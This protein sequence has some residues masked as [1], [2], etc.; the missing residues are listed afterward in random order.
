MYHRPD[1]GFYPGLCCRTLSGLSGMNAGT[2]ELIRVSPP[3]AVVY[4]KKPEC[5]MPMSL[6]SAGIRLGMNGN[7]GGGGRSPHSFFLRKNLRPPVGV[8]HTTYR[9]LFFVAIAVSLLI[10]GIIQP[11][12][13]QCT[14]ADGRTTL[15]LI[16]QDPHHHVHSE[17]F[18]ESSKSASGV[19]SS[20]CAD[21]DGGCMDLF[22]NHAAILRIGAHHPLPESIWGASGN[23]FAV[24]DSREFPVLALLS[25]PALQTSFHPQFKRPL[26]I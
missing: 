14:P 22:L 8:L 4:G 6:P 20:F 25:D 26:R 12:L 13:V 16:G 19:P 5:P 10:S 18:C 11:L 24:K 17:H 23:L 15:E 7:Q 3:E 2:A 1:P 9:N 21:V